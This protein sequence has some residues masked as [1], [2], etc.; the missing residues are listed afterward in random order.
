MLMADTKDLSQVMMDTV[1][2][3]DV[4]RSSAFKTSSSIASRK[5]F[6]L[7]HVGDSV[8]RA[9]GAIWHRSESEKVSF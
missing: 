4:K 2:L 6:G 7:A 3:V 5:S 1:S 9:L 8:R